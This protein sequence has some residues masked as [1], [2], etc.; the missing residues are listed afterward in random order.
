MKRPL[1]W[2]F[3]PYAAG[4]LA[5]NYFPAP[6]F[7]AAAVCLCLSMAA[8]VSSRL[9]PA[10]LYLL[11]LGCGCLSISISKAVL[12]PYDA[13]TVFGGEPALAAIRGT[14]NGSCTVREYD[15]GKRQV[16]RSTFEMDLTQ[17]RVNHGPWQPV[18]GRVVMTVNAPL[19][20]CFGGQRIEAEGV[21]APPKGAAAPGLFDY[22]AYLAWKGI[23]YHYAVSS[24]E[25]WKLL[26]TPSRPPAAQRFREWAC[27]ALEIGL[28]GEDDPLR[29]EWALTLGWRPA[30]TDEL[31]E[32]FLRAATFHIF[33]VDGLRMAIV[34][35]IFFELLRV[36]RAPRPLTGLIL[37]PVIWAYV[38]L[39]GWPASAIRATVML[40]IVILGWVFKRP[41]DLLNSLFAAA[42]VILAF[43]PRQ[44]FQ[45]GFQ[46]SFCVVLC[47]LV[48]M[49]LMEKATDRLLRKDPLLPPELQTR[50]PA[51]VAIPAKFAWG[52]LLVSF[53]AWIG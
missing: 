27:K 52:T 16:W 50:W 40:T 38:A 35:G 15:E 29:L 14:V 24:A 44:L 12:S 28:P 8:L 13:R 3:I 37:I 18:K 45:S 51:V 43:D 20:N 49:P 6:I 47:I 34:F 48:L 26:S 4:V 41:L 39:T 9:R 11:L 17:A 42:L 1:L 30:L 19:T 32:P 36:L 2:V 21:I 46:L 53:A 31:A 7:P 10:L 23:Y 22:R 33:A 5:G 25:D